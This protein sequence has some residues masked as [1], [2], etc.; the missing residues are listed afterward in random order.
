MGLREF[1]RRSEGAVGLIRD[2]RRALRTLRP[3]APAIRRYLATHAVRKLEIGAAVPRPDGWI[4][5][6]LEPRSRGVLPL[7]ATRRFPFQDGTFDFVFSE[8]MIEHVPWSAGLR[9]LGECFRVLRPGGIARIATPD[10]GRLLGLYPDAGDEP[11][12]QY[13]RWLA[14]SFLDEPLYRP[15]FAI[16]GVFRNWGHQFLYDRELLELALRRAGFTRLERPEYGKST[17]APL[18]LLERHGDEVGHVEAAA[19]EA[20]IV[21]AHKPGGG[22]PCGAAAPD[23]REPAHGR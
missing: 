11:A 3:R 7:D 23:S 18:Q 12:R 20:L 10:L 13:V 2:A 1:V 14:D 22:S 21:E 4:C 9:M 17:H 8:H 16:N 6:D 15:A 19:F 5:M